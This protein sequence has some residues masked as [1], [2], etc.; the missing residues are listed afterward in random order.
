MIIT[1]LV[2]YDGTDKLTDPAECRWNSMLPDLIRIANKENAAKMISVGHD[3]GSVCVSYLYCYFPD[4]VVGLIIVN[5]FR[6]SHPLYIDPSQL[7]PPPQHHCYSRSSEPS[8]N[9][10]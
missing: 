9:P 7:P 10:P 8:A 1:D 3:F 5:L 2:G 4:R 6:N